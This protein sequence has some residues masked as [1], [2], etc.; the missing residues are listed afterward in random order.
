MTK[1]I[2]CLL[3]A[4]CLLIAVPALAEDAGETM[5]S[6]WQTYQGRF[7]FGTCAPQSV[8]RDIK[9]LKLVKQQFNILTPEN[10]LKPDSV[11]DVGAS[12]KLVAETGDESQVAVRFD[13]AKPLL[14]FAKSGGLKVHGH[15]LF[16][17][18]QTPEAFFHEGYDAQNPFVTREV[19]LGRMENYVREIMAYLDENYP[20]VVVSW[21]VLNEAIDDGT[22]KLRHSRWYEVVGEDFPNQA[23]AFARKYA[24]EGTLL[25]YNDYNTAMPGKL[26]GIIALLNTLIPEGNIDGYGFQMHHSVNYPTMQLITAAMEKIAALGLRLRV[27]EMDIGVERNDEAN[28]AKQARMYADI[29]KLLLR[30]SDQVE[31]VQVWGIKDNMSWRATDFPLLFDAGGNPKSAFWAVIDPDGAW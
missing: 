21:D 15:V 19:M 11:L 24:P 30:F 25:Y 12:K 20:G 16:W 8:F 22:N 6:L 17:H 31:A 13:A 10:E 4:L 26:Y 5:P 9:T 23:F 7:D 28:F 27:S 29:M 18:A 3:L 14:N 2:C 1:R